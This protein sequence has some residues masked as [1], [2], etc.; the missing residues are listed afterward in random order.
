MNEIYRAEALPS[1]TADRAR[2]TTPV[3]VLMRSPEAREEGDAQ[4]AADQVRTPEIH[5]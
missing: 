3:A 5:C 2:A 1:L 4:D